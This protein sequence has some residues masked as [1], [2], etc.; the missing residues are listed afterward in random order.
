MEPKRAFIPACVWLFIV[1]LVPCVSHAATFDVV[2]AT[3]PAST[4]TVDLT[5]AAMSGVTPEFAVCTTTRATAN[6]T[7]TANGVWSIGAAANDGSASQFAAGVAA[8]DNVGTSL[9]S[10]QFFTDHVYTL[11]DPTSGPGSSIGEGVLSFISGG[12]RITVDDADTASLINCLIGAGTDIEAE[13][14]LGQYPGSS[15]NNDVTIAHGLGGTPDLAIV[16]SAT[17]TTVATNARAGVGFWARTAPSEA[18]Y[19][20]QSAT[21]AAA[22][23]VAAVASATV[24]IPALSGNPSADVQSADAT[25][26]VVRGTNSATDY[27]RVLFVRGVSNQIE[28][29]TGS[30]STETSTGSDDKITGFTLNVKAGLLIGTQLGSVTSST[31]GPASVLSLGMFAHNGTSITQGAALVA[32][33]ESADPT[34]AN[35][36][37]NSGSAQVLT[38]NAGVIDYVATVTTMDTEVTFNTTDADSGTNTF[39][40][41]A[42]GT[43]AASAGAFDTTP[44]V[45]NRTSSAYTVTGSLSGAGDVDA[46][47][48]IKDQTAP[49]IV[50]VQ[51]GDCT[52]GVDAKAVDDDSPAMAP[53]DFSLTLAP[54]DNPDFPV[55]DIYVTDGTTLT[56]LV[57]ECL[58]P[59]ASF[60]FLNCPSGLTSLG[61]GSVPQAFNDADFVTLAYD[62]QT[63]NFTAGR[64]VLG[65]TSG[66][67]GIIEA[68]TDAGATGTLT[69]DKRSGTFQDNEAL[70]DSGG[71][72]AVVN[73]TASNVAN[74]A[75]GD[76]LVIP[77]TVSPSGAA[78]SAENDGDVSYIASGKQAALN[79]RVY[80]LSAGAYMALDID[81]YANNNAPEC[82][83]TASFVFALDE[84]SQIDA[85]SFCNDLDL[86]SLTSGRVSTA[87]FPSM[88][89]LDPDTNIVGG[90]PDTEE[91]KNLVVALIDDA[92]ALGLWSFTITVSEGFLVP[93]CVSTPTNASDCVAQIL[94]DTLGSVFVTTTFQCTTQADDGYVFSQDPEGGDPAELGGEV[95]IVVSLGPCS[96]PNCL[97]ST[98]N[99]CDLLITNHPET[100][101][102]T[103]NDSTGCVNGNSRIYSQ[104]PAVGAEADSDFVVTVFC[105]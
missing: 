53:Y 70:T 43:A 63:A 17:T 49:T 78:L 31:G 96:V 28:A 3:L 77:T 66:A 52:G 5:S 25:N 9:T 22:G 2:Q 26:F 95:S 72:A 87:A 10:S 76:I 33:E 55:Y 99:Q 58:D 45:S 50:Q 20:W 56:S 35:S 46:V 84:E 69:I 75:T 62:G 101:D 24:A 13:I 61:A 1:L 6:D 37:I 18:G 94:A 90:T 92:K 100:G 29:R 12:V 7:P 14:G 39:L 79:W 32:D 83:E 36:V 89:T 85:D 21:A 93:D 74:I 40:Y 67:Y 71:G 27:V 80:D 60:Q 81:F 104:S 4:T 54:S 65:G 91:E 8:R 38:T 34:N 102:A 97:G 68:D 15:S 16:V 47:V 98:V 44:G 23:D 30:F 59:P 51:A 105:R 82:R 48:C 41:L 86:E 19:A 57:D 64:I 73:G 103:L 88:V 11:G 42:L